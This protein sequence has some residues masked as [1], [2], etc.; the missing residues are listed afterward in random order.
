M[1]CHPERQWRGIN[2][3]PPNFHQAVC[4]EIPSQSPLAQL[5]EDD[6]E[7]AT[8]L[9]MLSNGCTACDASGLWVRQCNPKLGDSDAEPFGMGGINK[10]YSK[11]LDCRFECSS[12]MRTFGSHQELVVHSASHKN[13]RG[14]FDVVRNDGEEDDNEKSSVEGG[15]VRENEEEKMVM[16][17]G[18]KC[19][20][21]WNVFSSGEALG[22]HKMRCHWKKGDEH[23]ASSSSTRGSA[24]DLNLPAPQEN[25]DSPHDL[26]GTKAG[27]F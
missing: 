25:E 14:D 12:C 22:G 24:L 10:T 13:V 18:H 9:L 27:D 17:F 23:G 6:H 2:P 15:K 7:V 5:T 20:T 19:S 3:P 26:F 16:I 8:C 21:C 4:T 1:R 11:T